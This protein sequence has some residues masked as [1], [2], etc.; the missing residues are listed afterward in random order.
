VRNLLGKFDCD[1]A[2]LNWERIRR[3]VTCSRHRD[4]NPSLNK[5]IIQKV[6]SQGMLGWDRK[7]RKHV[8]ITP[9]TGHE[10]PIGVALVLKKLYFR[11]SPPPPVVC[12]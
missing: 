11:L 8:R 9:P 3:K 2:Q 12:V 5:C 4:T 6:T 10:F 1:F 7:R